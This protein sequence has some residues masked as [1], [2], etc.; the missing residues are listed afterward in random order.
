MIEALLD[1]QHPTGRRTTG[2]RNA[3]QMDIDFAKP[4]LATPT[5]LIRGMV[6]R[7][8]SFESQAA[9]VRVLPKL[10]EIQRNILHIL[11][12]EP[13]GLTAKELEG[14]IEFRSYSPNSVRKR[15]SELSQAK[16]IVQNGR[17]EG[18]AV[19]VVAP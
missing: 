9:A 12:T 14:R 4:V 18:C 10:T 3:T 16:K 17:R 19:W 7:S 2:V 11:A 13:A 5:R 6:E 15:C 1:I 8:D